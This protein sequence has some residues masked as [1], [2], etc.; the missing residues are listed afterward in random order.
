MAIKCLEVWLP[1]TRTIKE[2]LQTWRGGDMSLSACLKYYVRWAI[3]GAMTNI[4]TA[5]WKIP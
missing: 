5:Q 3:G 1:L 2:V 4:S